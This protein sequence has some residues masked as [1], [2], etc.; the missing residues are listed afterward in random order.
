[1]NEFVVFYTES[2][3]SNRGSH[4][5]GVVMEE[6]VASREVSAGSRIESDGYYAT[7]RYIGTVASANGEI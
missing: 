7:I 5:V 6:G 4:Q 3:M 1:M 2:V